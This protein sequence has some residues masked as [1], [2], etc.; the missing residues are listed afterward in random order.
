MRRGGS[1]GSLAALTMIVPLVLPVTATAAAPTTVFINEIHYDN[2]STDAGEAIEVAGPAGTNLSG[3]SLV[4]Y[5][6]NGGGVY[7]T[8]PLSGTIP[9]QSAGFGTVVVTYPVNGIQN[10]SPDGVA[11]VDGAT[12]V[13]FLSYEGTFTATDGPASG[14]TS[15]N[16]GVSESSSTPV[17]ASLQLTGTGT[18]YE[19][20]TWASPA[21][22]T[23]GSVNTGQTFGAST[24]PTAPVINEFSAS[25]TG[26][27]RRVRGDLRRPRDGLLLVH[28]PGGRG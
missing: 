4:L 27:E 9:D 24:G 16:I 26:T 25:T 1:L 20:F 14:T 11:L 28:R 18:V 10:G 13:Q 19:D 7:D 17:G 3:W 23:F 2:D 21:A 8:D 15:T 22:N 5:N 12:V 6:G